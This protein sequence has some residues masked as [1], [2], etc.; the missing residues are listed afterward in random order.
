MDRDIRVPV[1]AGVPW[2]ALT[3]GSYIRLM[4]HPREAAAKN[5]VKKRE[6]P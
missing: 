6:A 5:S 4:G 1:F 2:A 3:M